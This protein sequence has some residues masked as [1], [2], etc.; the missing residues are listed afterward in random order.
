MVLELWL[1]LKNIFD[2][3]LIFCPDKSLLIFPSEFVVEGSDKKLNAFFFPLMI[4][5]DNISI[6]VLWFSLHLFSWLEESGPLL[7]FFPFFP[8]SVVEF[9]FLTPDVPSPGSSESSESF[10]LFASPLHLFCFFFYICS[11][12]FSILSSYL[13]LFFPVFSC[14]SLNVSFG[15]RFSLP[16]QYVFSFFG[17]SL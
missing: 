7:S 1:S 5:K 16:V 4:L 12:S 10:L 14:F 8:F 3:I 2:L 9:S 6:T 13:F 15:G 11:P 17:L